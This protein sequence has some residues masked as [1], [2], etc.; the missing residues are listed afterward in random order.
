MEQLAAEQGT[1]PIEDVS[2]LCGDFWPEEDSGADFV[3][4][5]DLWRAD[6]VRRTRA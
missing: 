6:Q 5:V 4:A 1:G 3:A 2:L